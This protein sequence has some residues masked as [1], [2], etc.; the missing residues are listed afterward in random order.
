MQGRYIAATTHITNC[1]ALANA[2]IDEDTG[3]SLEYAALSSGP[4]KEVWIRAL[5][6]DIGRLAQGVGA[7]IKGN[8]TMFFIHPSKIPRGRK[9]TYGRLVASLRPNKAEVNRVRLTI[10]GDRLDYVGSTT[11]RMAS[12]TTTKCLLNSVVSTQNAKF[13]GLDIKDFYYKTP[14][15]TYEYMQLPLKII[16][17]EIIDEYDLTSIAVKDIVYIEIRKG[18][19]GLKQA[20]R[21]ANDRLTVHLAKHGYFPVPRTP[22]L[23]RHVSNGVTFTLVCDDFGVKYTNKASADHLIQALKK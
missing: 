23:W 16:P 22:Q 20:G 6:N 15:E 13:M 4:D 8:S 11:T 1:E 14:L 21:L 19:P 18:M 3:T 9:V 2:V 10:G 7:R 5:A 12:L 17:Q